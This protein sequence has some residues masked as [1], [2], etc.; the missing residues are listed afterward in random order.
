MS[1][2]KQKCTSRTM[3]SGPFSLNEISNLINIPST[4]YSTTYKVPDVAS[5]STTLLI[6]F[7][8]HDRKPQLEYEFKA[9]FLLD[10]KCQRQG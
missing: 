9:H 4:E 10:E 2:L 8:N 1:W 6:K 3:R 5:A 7:N